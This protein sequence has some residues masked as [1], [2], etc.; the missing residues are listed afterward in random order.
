MSRE[1]GLPTLLPG[2]G[3]GAPVASFNLPESPIAI[4]CPA[5]IWARVGGRGQALDVYQ[6]DNRLICV[7]RAP[8]P[9]DVRLGR[10]LRLP[11]ELLRVDLDPSSGALQLQVRRLSLGPRAGRRWQQALAPAAVPPPR[12]SRYCSGPGS[13]GAPHPAPSP[14]SASEHAAS[15]L[16]RGA[17]LVPAACW[18]A[19]PA[20][21]AGV[22]ALAWAAGQILLPP[23][24]RALALGLALHRYRRRLAAAPAALSTP[25]RGRL[26]DVVLGRPWV[27]TVDL[28]QPFVVAN[29]LLAT[30]S[31]AWLRTQC[32]LQ[33]RA[34]EVTGLRT[35]QL[36]LGMAMAELLPATVFGVQV[37]HLWLSV[38]H[39][40]EGQAPDAMHLSL[41]AEGTRQSAAGH[42]P[43]RLRLDLLQPWPRPGDLARSPS[44]PDLSAVAA[45]PP[46][47]SPVA[48]RSHPFRRRGREDVQ[49]S[50]AL[51]H[52]LGAFLAAA[53]PLGSATLSGDAI[54]LPGGS[55]GGRHLAMRPGQQLEVRRHA[56]PLR[57]ADSILTLAAPAGGYECGRPAQVW[58]ATPG[59]APSQLLGAPLRAAPIWLQAAAL[60]QAGTARLAA[61]GRAW[62]PLRGPHLNAEACHVRPWRLLLAA[63]GHWLEGSLHPHWLMPNA[64]L[65]LAGWLGLRRHSGLHYALSAPRVVTY[66]GGEAY[67]AESQLR[68][69]LHLSRLRCTLREQPLRISLPR[70][71][72]WGQRQVDFARPLYGQILPLLMAILTHVDEAAP[73]RLRGCTANPRELRIYRTG[74]S[75]SLEI[76]G[77]LGRVRLRLG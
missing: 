23:W 68:L 55:F 77:P 1:N 21:A 20:L 48:R 72:F 30:G 31:G 33:V 28:R 46:T 45:A 16:R 5:G 38:R 26:R 41:Q 42:E 10:H 13:D 50:R 8:L 22:T 62:T 52:G 18:L 37:E 14:R 4:P 44:A 43:V 3:M 70:P 53:R 66:N 6:Q 24:G 27:F 35:C 57:P 11:A 49:A 63:P 64:A 73:L 12:R 56:D 60:L 9:L 65:T 67:L 39:Q 71:E 40:A 36:N 34:L 15:S 74:N 19:P 75:L 7:P 17:G 29:D 54:R 32:E 47:R 61:L 76:E 2:L 59:S 51:V 25:W 58:V 69:E